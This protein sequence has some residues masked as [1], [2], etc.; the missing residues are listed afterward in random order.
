V[1]V[2]AGAEFCH[3]FNVAYE[4]RENS[5]LKSSD[6]EGGTMRSQVT[7]CEDLVMLLG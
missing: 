3:G 5:S 7:T 4:K 6:D 2:D 1:E